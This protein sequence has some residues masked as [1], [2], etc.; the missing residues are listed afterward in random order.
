[1]AEEEDDEVDEDDE[2]DV[3]QMWDQSGYDGL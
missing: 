3:E 2:D 1:M